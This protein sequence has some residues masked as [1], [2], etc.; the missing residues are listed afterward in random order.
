MVQNNRGFTLIELLITVVII[1]ILAS[2]AIPKFSATKDKAYLAV[3]KSDLRNFVLAEEAY[4]ADYGTYGTSTNVVTAGLFES[5]QHVNLVSTDWNGRGYS[6]E[7]THENLRA[8]TTQTCGVFVGY[9]TPPD[10]SLYTE[11]AVG[12]Y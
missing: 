7:A 5:S 1:G 4:F 12:C 6:A 10:A 11:G 2:T 9:A 3:L 8:T